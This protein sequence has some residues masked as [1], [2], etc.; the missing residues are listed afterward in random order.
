MSQNKPL[1]QKQEAFARNY[2]ANGFNATQA[3]ISAGYSEDTARSEGSRLLT[4][5]DIQKRIAELQS[6]TVAKS[7]IGAEE[8]YEFASRAAFFDIGEVLEMDETGVYFKDGKKLSDLS[9]E[10]RQLVQTVRSKPT[11]FGIVNE[12]IFVDKM[13]N[14]EMLARF[15]GMNKDTLE[16]TKTKLSADERAARLAEL[17][18]KAGLKNGAD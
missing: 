11:K 10:L 5:V 17:A 4:N 18:K 16:V 1:T 15:N 13:K 8:I 2:V 6:E 3:A 9:V 7:K 12:V 14:L